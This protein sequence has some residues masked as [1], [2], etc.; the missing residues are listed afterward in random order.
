MRSLRA[1]PLIMKNPTSIYLS[2]SLSLC[3]SL[4]LVAFHRL[5]WFSSVH[6]GFSCVSFVM[7]VTLLAVLTP[8]NS[9]ALL[10]GIGDPEEAAIGALLGRLKVSSSR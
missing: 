2:L 4:L 6:S 8:A 7:I 5:E 9:E 1:L 10:C 3:I